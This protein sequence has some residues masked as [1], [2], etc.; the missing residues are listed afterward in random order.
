MGVEEVLALFLRVHY[1]LGDLMV[2]LSISFSIK[3]KRK[4]CTHGTY[5]RNDMGTKA[6]VLPGIKTS[7][8]AVIWLYDIL[9]SLNCGIYRVKPCISLS[10]THKSAALLPDP[11]P[12]VVFATNTHKLFAAFS[13]GCVN[14]SF[15]NL[16]YLA[17]LLRFILGSG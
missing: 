11:A 9:W 7:L 13:H 10:F 1:L 14:I 16:G 12:W 15:T 17:W 8:K 5:L 6:F 2:I 3:G 4:F